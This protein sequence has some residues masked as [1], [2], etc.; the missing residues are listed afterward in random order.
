MKNGFN[1]FY[2]GQAISEIKK[3]ASIK[4][5]GKDK[6]NKHLSYYEVKGIKEYRI[7]DYYLKSITLVFYDD[8]LYSIH[9]IPLFTYS[10][11]DNNIIYKD[12]FKR[13]QEQ[14]GAFEEIEVTAIDKL[15]GIQHKYEMYGKKVLLRF[16][17]GIDA[18]QFFD[19]NI[20]EKV[21]Q[22]MDSGL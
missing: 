15:S 7:F 8:Y 12:I 4:S 10:K 11:E 19:I 1:R 6:D 14:Y 2:L 3:I 13:I 17:S 5:L 18:Y 16:S 9:V 21:S 20:R 22:K